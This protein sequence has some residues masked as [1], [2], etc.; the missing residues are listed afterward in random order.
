[1]RLMKENIVT[2]IGGSDFRIIT[3]AGG[4]FTCATEFETG[5]ELESH[6]VEVLFLSP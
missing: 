3:F 6:P 5:R 1:M 4:I 2:F